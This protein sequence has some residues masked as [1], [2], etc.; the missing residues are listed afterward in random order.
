MTIVKKTA[1]IVAMSGLL[2][3]AASVSTWAGMPAGNM[4]APSHPQVLAAANGPMSAT[5]GSVD[6][7]LARQVTYQIHSN[8]EA[9]HMYGADNVVG[10]KNACIMGGYAIPGGYGVGLAI[11]GVG[12]ASGV[13]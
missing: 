11:G 10:D 12:M 7:S 1:V 9:S 8:C 6:S 4:S 13:R 3:G 5:E 2:M